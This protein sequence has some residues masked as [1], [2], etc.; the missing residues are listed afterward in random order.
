MTKEEE[1]NSRIRGL[2]SREWRLSVGGEL[3]AADSLPTYPIED[4]STGQ[5]IALAPNGGADVANAAVTAAA[6]AYGGWRSLLIFERAAHLQRLAAAIEARSEDF[7]LLDAVCGGGPVA[8]MRKDVTSAVRG[9]R[10]F[11]G[12]APQLTGDTIPASEHL[13]IT[14]R[15]PFGVVA[16]IV[17]F[18]HPF[19]FS[20]AKAAAPLMAG[21]T[22]IIKPPE[23]APLSALLFGEIA[24]EIL[25]K[26]VLSVVVGD[27]PEVP[28]A[29]VRHPE[30][31]RIGFVGSEP[32]GRAI[33]EEAAR[34]GVKTVTLELGGKNALIA[35]HDADVDQVASAAVQGMNF[36]WAGQSCGS[37]SRLL[38]HE[39]IANLVVERIVAIV[40][41]I[42]IG[43]AIDEATEQGPLTSH[44]QFE[45]VSEDIASAL[46]DGATL[47]TGGKRPDHLEKG[48]FLEPTVFDHV[49]PGMRI[50]RTEVFGP[51][52]SVMRWSDPQD[53]IGIANSVQYG[54]TAAIF[55]PDISQALQTARALE[56]GFIW[57]NG[58]SQH[59]TGVPY[60]G[61]KNSGI[62]RDNAFEELH[63]YTQTKAINIFIE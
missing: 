21:N 9:L 58:V 8:D 35:F 19:L 14:E 45:R 18:N 23:S 40:Q 11:A 16:R 26:G 41:K 42:Q 3:Q 49:T 59:F 47:V 36:A 28:R 15:I 63:S 5:A 52:L 29:L 39:D 54:L 27:G 6:A 53:A 44:R 61:V 32:T 48:H 43:P 31:R 50:A 56:V 51:V 20:V 33:Q 62:G 38:V 7:A 55:T 25:P 37:T 46:S 4:P 34:A 2:L 1:R 24:A 17:A 60:G 13:H 30:V 12:I 57:I 10:Y 22:V